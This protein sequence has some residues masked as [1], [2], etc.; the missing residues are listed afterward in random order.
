MMH[1]DGQSRT[2]TFQDET[3]PEET[4][5]TYF[6]YM[7]KS[8]CEIG[9]ISKIYGTSMNELCHFVVLDTA[10]QKSCCSSQWMEHYQN[11]LTNHRMK[12]KFV[13][14]REPFEFGH[15]PTQ[16]SDHH[17]YMPVCFD[18]S[19]ST[20]CLLGAYV[21]PN[22]NDIPFLGSHSLMQKL[23]MVLDLPNNKVRIGSLRCEVEMHMV[24]GH[25]A[26]K[27][28]HLP[29]GSCHESVWKTLSMLSDQPEADA[30]LIAPPKPS[31]LEHKAKIPA[32]QFTDAEPV[33]TPAMASQLEAPGEAVLSCRD[34]PGDDNAAGYQASP[35]SSILAST[36]GS[37]GHGAA[38]GPDGKGRRTMSSREDPKVRKQVRPLCKVSGL[39]DELAVGRGKAKMGLK[40]IAKAAISTLAILFNSGGLGEESS[41]RMGH[42]SSERANVPTWG[43][44]DTEPINTFHQETGEV[45]SRQTQ[46][47]NSRQAQHAGGGRGRLRLG[48]GGGLG[49]KKE[50]NY[51]WLASHLRA[52]QRLYNYE[53]EAYKTLATYE[54]IHKEGGKIDL[55]EVFSGRGRL[56]ASAHRYGLNALQPIDSNEGFDLT[57]YEG[58]CITMHALSQFKPLLLVVAWPCTVWSIMNENSN[59]SHRPEELAALRQHERPLVDFSAD[60]CSTQI[61]EQRLYLGENPLKS[62]IWSEKKVVKLFWHP[63]TLVTTCH[64][65]AYGAEDA[66]GFPIIK[67]HRW[68]TNSTYIAKE[69]Q[70]KMTP[71]QQMYARP[72]EGSRTKASGEYCQ[73]LANAILRGLLK[74]ARKRNPT[75]FCE[76]ARVFYARPIRDE[77]AWNHLL[78]EVEKR[79]QN[80]Y[81]RPFNLGKSDELYKLVANLV[82]WQL[83]RVQAAWTPA[84]R[85]WPEDVP[86]THRGAALRTTT[87]QLVIE[88]EDLAAAHYPKQRYAQPMRVGV[89]FF[90]AAAD[91]EQDQQQEE[92]P[93]AAEPSTQPL[94]GFKT[95]IWFEGGPAD[96]PRELKASL[97]RL[98]VNMG[99]ASREEL[100][101]ILAASN[102]LNAKVIA[103][104]DA[105][106]CGSCIRLKQPK[107]PP[108]SSTAA[109]SQH[110]GFFGENLESDIVY[111]RILTGEAVPV[112]GILC[113]FTNYHCA[114][115]LPDRQ[116]ETYAESVQGDLVQ[117]AGTANECHGRPRWCIPLSYAGMA[118][119]TWN[120]LHCHPR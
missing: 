66:D 41:P 58:K 65:G 78:D 71:E 111:M 80:T 64:A 67:T 96:F 73:G 102:N 60:L 20:T 36:S 11:I 43:E 1:H 16:F 25:L 19:S 81:K 101:P 93:E 46:E 82:P 76:T 24:N 35:S 63:D 118:S 42:E 89:F 70:L 53:V 6:T 115:V 56:T 92:R 51:A 45:A 3:S 40:G 109:T 119:T 87:G 68:L 94:P 7:V 54:R 23:Q 49:E 4:Y 116:P 34:V 95:E 74:E 108:T 12:V 100:V 69:L 85:R 18:G 26:L 14:K 50:A 104:L 117:A 99:H 2:V 30:E 22:T 107:K 9:N 28:D 8:P 90:G 32:D 79:F 38:D 62:R 83:E 88:D 37:H 75:R 48:L 29:R 84:A 97:A 33:S 86:F 17:A 120:Q 114:K 91:D 105:L 10:C 112:V 13:K 31:P 103:G 55:M 27:I 44:L 59:Y 5:G 52:Q 113:G 98:H 57:T 39:P 47:E 21:I 106:R 15:G 61:E 72:I 77:T 110:S